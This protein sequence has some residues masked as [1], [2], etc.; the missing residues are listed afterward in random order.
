MSAAFDG[1]D[2]ISF[3]AAPA[4]GPSRGSGKG[5][6]AQASEAAGATRN[7]ITSML[8][9]AT[10]RRE[11]E[12]NQAG[13]GG[14]H[15]GGAGGSSSGATPAAQSKSG[16]GAQQASVSASANGAGPS[17]SG[18]G[19][20]SKAAE[21]NAPS[22]SRS[23]GTKRK[24][25]EIT[26]EE[27][28]LSKKERQ[29]LYAASTPWSVEVDWDRCRNGAE[30]LHR[31]IMAFD[32]WLMPTTAELE[33]RDMV[34]AL[35][36]KA[37]QSK[38]SDADVRPFGSHNT[39]LYLP[40][41]DIDL[42]VL[43]S[44]M[45]TQPREVVLRNMAY[46]LR[47]NNLTSGNVQ[48]IAKAKVP[49]IKFICSY[50]DYK[51]DISV[52]QANGLT[53]ADYVCNNLE[54]QPAL[55]PIIM[56]VKQLLSSR[57]LSEVYVGGLGSYSVILSVIS[58]MQMHPRI[59]RCE[60][61][62]A[63]NL[64]VLLL[65]YLELYGKRFAY[66]DLGISVRGKGSYFNKSMR[67]F[68]DYRSTVTKMCI[69]D[70]LDPN[71]DV[72]S[73]SFNFYEVRSAW[74]GAFDLITS[75]IGERSMSLG[76]PKGSRPTADQVRAAA[77]KKSNSR[78]SDEE[79]EWARQ[80][81]MQ[82]NDR[83]GAKDPM[84]LLGKIFGIKPSTIKHRKKIARLWES[85]EMQ[86]KLGRPTARI[87]PE[88]GPSS[89][90]AVDLVQGSNAGR[91]VANPGANGSASSARRAEPTRAEALGNSLPS[92]N[93]A[94][95]NGIRAAAAQNAAQGSSHKGEDKASAQV[96][97][98]SAEKSR[99]TGKQRVEVG[100]GSTPLTITPQES[101]GE[102]ESRYATSGKARSAI[103][104]IPAGQT[105]ESAYVLDDSS[106]SAGESVDHEYAAAADAMYAGND[107][108]EDD[109][110]EEVE[111]ARA[112]KRQRNAASSSDMAAV[113]V[114]NS[115]S[116]AKR[117]ATRREVDD[118][119]TSKGNALGPQGEGSAG[120]G[121]SSGDDDIVFVGA[122]QSSQQ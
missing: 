67:G 97:A 4:A 32:E 85:N 77:K 53:A 111:H 49:I 24:H 113:A 50:G 61:D 38:W 30:M 101:D 75:A 108:G 46:I 10:A 94:V 84:S 60:I 86:N 116:P 40:E 54:Q 91:R 2:F 37:I 83:A 19:G 20:A 89:S 25:H 121:G 82:E 9:A 33:C 17:A 105:A 7:R 96:D 115:S 73:G 43:S 80:M 66:D 117:R 36:R 62:P 118:Y 31:E 28:R 74:S 114:P 45:N 107:D 104:L 98:A 109:A 93:R 8:N 27:N 15:G 12:K 103:T 59:Q 81:L 14:G 119:W 112:R 56:V 106:S 39:R 102:E 21:R 5:G 55:R 42:V 71:N 87:T 13:G 1:E 90:R 18:S 44:S 23:G 95:T 70:P 48:V 26:A 51:V 110:E 35:I 78:Y 3:D 69:E 99:R 52:N 58:F 122:A 92:L 22:S 47:T 16:A 120:G 76:G 63:R 57:N 68:V 64:G 65:E 6:G 34:I 100:T 72:A 11:A 29:E 88:P 79:D 41:G